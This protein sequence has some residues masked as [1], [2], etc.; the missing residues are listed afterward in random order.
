[1][2]KKVDTNLNFGQREN[3]VVKFWDENNIY[4]ISIDSRKKGESYVF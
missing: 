4:E 1:M 2:Y 3:E